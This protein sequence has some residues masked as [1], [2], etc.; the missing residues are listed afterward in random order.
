MSKVLI[1]V[2]G[3]AD[4]IFLRDYIK[5]LKPNCI[6]DDSQLKAKKIKY[7]KLS[8]ANKEIKILIGRGY[9]ALSNLS[10]RINEHKD[11]GYKIVTIQDADDP[12][13]ENGGVSNRM[14]YLEQ[15][16]SD[17]K[18]DFDIFLFPNHKDDG[19][20]E[21][22]LLRINNFTHYD[23]SNNC[24]ENYIKCCEQISEQNFSDELRE[25]KSK[26]FNYFR[27]YYGMKS[28]KE[29]NRC[30][31]NKYWDFNHQELSA[32]KEFLGRIMSDKNPISR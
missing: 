5:F 31:E 28:A 7:L 25:D 22:L 21:T 11:D 16:K 15:I 24:Y 4:V 2:E 26:V 8:I 12:E 14:K 32:L 17:N 19:D 18:I 27:T 9:T 13:K 23:I 1:I 3:I 30:Y 20:L 29:E 6:A 10:Q